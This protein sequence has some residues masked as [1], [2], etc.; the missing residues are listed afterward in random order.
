[1]NVLKQHTVMTEPVVSEGLGSRGA[2][3]CLSC[4]FLF[5]ISLSPSPFSGFST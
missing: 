1:M 4:F 5:L 2:S 3:E